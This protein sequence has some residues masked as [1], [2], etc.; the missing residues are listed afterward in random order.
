[1]A[2]SRPHIAGNGGLSGGFENAWPDATRIRSVFL[3]HAGSEF[4]PRMIRS[5]LQNIAENP[6]HVVRY[7]VGQIGFTFIHSNHFDYTIRLSPRF[8]RRSHSVKWR[9]ERQIVVLKGAGVARARLLRV[10]EHLDINDFRVG[11]MLEE[12]T[13][14]SLTPES[15]V[16]TVSRSEILDIYEVESP[17]L[18]E[19]LTIRANDVD[20]YWTFDERLTSR[21]AEAS[22]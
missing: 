6:R 14:L 10:P 9:G 7:S 13:M 21:Y 8:L 3:Q 4:L 20:L 2:R 12:A 18:I 5:E 1:L 16:E 22:L 11:E 15:P 19:A 17:L